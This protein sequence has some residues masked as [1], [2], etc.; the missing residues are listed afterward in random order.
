M[1]FIDRKKIEPIIMYLEH[2]NNNKKKY[3]RLCVR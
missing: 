2:Q 3:V 1:R